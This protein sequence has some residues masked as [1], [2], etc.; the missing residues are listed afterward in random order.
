MGLPIRE[1]H[2][3]RKIERAIAR[4]DSRLTAMYSMFTC[5]NR[6]DA[7][8]RLERIR[9]RVFRRAVRAKRAATL[10]SP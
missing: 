3:L 8:P 4:T 5:L 7:M 9:A 10:S 6:P 1:R 2:K